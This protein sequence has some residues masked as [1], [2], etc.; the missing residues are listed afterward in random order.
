[1]RYFI[2][3]GANVGDRLT[4]LREAARRLEALGTVVGR[5]RVYAAAPVGG[6]PQAPYLNAAIILDCELEPVAL[7]A[8]TQEIEDALGRDRPNE[9]RWGPRTLDIDL[10]MCG[11]RGEQIVDEPTLRLPHPRMKERGFALAPLVELDATL[12]HP[13][14]ARPLKALLSAALAA[15]QAWAP[16]GDTL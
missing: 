4:N 6:P 1:M 7:L 9:V 13:E 8:R 16:T 2:G 12:M 5:S 3:L 10:L 14:L 15:G 11:M